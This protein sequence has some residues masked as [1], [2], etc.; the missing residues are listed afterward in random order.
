MRG[1]LLNGSKLAVEIR[2]CVF[3]CVVQKRASRG[4]T[5]SLSVPCVSS[6]STAE[7][8]EKEQRAHVMI[9]GF[10]GVSDAAQHEVPANCWRQR[11]PSWRASWAQRQQGRPNVFK[12]VS[13]GLLLLPSDCCCSFRVAAASAGCCCFRR[14][15]V[16]S[17][18][19]VCC[20]FTNQHRR[21]GPKCASKVDETN[22]VTA[23]YPH[24]VLRH[25]IRLG[26]CPALIQTSHAWF[27]VV[28]CL[29]NLGDAG[30]LS[31]IAGAWAS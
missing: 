1:K 24:R 29:C 30:L 17:F 16:A 25:R 20:C 3:R 10:V 13:F 31:E 12:I 8:S 9:V 14:I 11:L 21:R 18:G 15:A 6:P 4:V 27:N 2:R 26:S 5:S 28:A 23:Q 22:K 7:C 19:S